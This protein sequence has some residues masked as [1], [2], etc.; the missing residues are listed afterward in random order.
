[1]S[2]VIDYFCFFLY[3]TCVYNSPNKPL[4]VWNRIK[5]MR[6]KNE[7]EYFIRKNSRKGK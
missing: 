3:N 2:I 7:K 5:N 6:E 4:G 1:M